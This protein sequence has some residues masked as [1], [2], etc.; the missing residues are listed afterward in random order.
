MRTKHTFGLRQVARTPFTMGKRIK[1]S[2]I[3]VVLAISFPAE[4]WKDRI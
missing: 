4:L 3:I 2:A 1:A